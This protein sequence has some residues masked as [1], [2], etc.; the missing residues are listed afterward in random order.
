MNLLGAMDTTGADHALHAPVSDP[1]LFRVLMV[2][3]HSEEATTGL[4]EAVGIAKKALHDRGYTV[5]VDHSV[6]DYEE[7][8]SVVRSSWWS[9]IVVWVRGLW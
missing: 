5:S 4:F 1:K 2:G 7:P 6:W 8:D 9:R 3:T